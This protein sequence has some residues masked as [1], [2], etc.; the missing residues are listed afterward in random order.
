MSFH[1]QKARLKLK[2]VIGVQVMRAEREDWQGGS[3]IGYRRDDRRL[4]GVEDTSMTV[5]ATSTA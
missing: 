3:A 2:L 1:E 4:G 5:L